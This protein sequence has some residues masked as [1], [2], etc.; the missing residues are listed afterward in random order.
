MPFRATEAEVKKIIDT[1]LTEEEIT[2][3]L[4]ASS[5]LIDDVLSGAQYSDDLMKQIEIWLAAHFVAVRDPRISREKFGDLDV[6]FHGKTDLGLNSTPYGQ[7]AMILDYK[8]RLAEIG[9]NKGPA[10]VKTII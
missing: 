4:T 2:P 9:N 1:T 3:F 6:Q 8:G 7:Q 10:E 5:I